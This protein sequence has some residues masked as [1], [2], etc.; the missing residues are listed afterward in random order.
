MPHPTR[1]N[2]LSSL[3]AFRETALCGLLRKEPLGF[4]DIGARGGAH[5]LVDPL[6][7]LIHVI[8]FEPDEDAFK[9]LE[10]ESRGSPFAKIEYSR[11]ALAERAGAHPLYL[12]E[13][14]TNHSLRQPNET[15]CRRYNMVKF[16]CRGE[17]TVD[18]ETLDHLLVPRLGAEPHLGELIK[19]DTQG[20][21]H[22]ILRGAEEILRRQTVALFVEVSFCPIY[23]G[24]SQFSELEIY[25]RG[26]GFVFHGFNEIHYRS[27]KALDKRHEAGRERLLFSDAIFFKDP[28]ETAGQKGAGERASGTLFLCA[29][30]FGH[31]DFALELLPRVTAREKERASLEAVVHHCAARNPSQ[32]VQAL[33]QLQERVIASPELANVLTGRFVDSRRSWPDYAE[34]VTRPPVPAVETGPLGF[35]SVNSVSGSPAFRQTQL[36]QEFLRQPLGFI[37]VGARGGIHTIVQPMAEVTAVLALEPDAP[38]AERLRE[39]SKAS[40]FQQVNI[41]ACGLAGR[42]GNYDLNLLA[43]SVNHSLL[44]PNQHLVDRYRIR[45]FEPAGT[46]NVPCRSLDSLLLGDLGGETFWGEF[47]KIDTQGAE[48]DILNGGLQVLRDRT[49]ALVVEACFFQLYENQRCFPDLEWWLRGQG[50]SLYGFDHLNYRSQKHLDKK[51]EA[52]RERL[53]F[54]DAIFFRDPFDEI[55]RGRSLTRRNIACLIAAAILLRYYDFALELLALWEAPEAERAGLRAA[56]HQAAFHSPAQSAA[57]VARLHQAVAGHPDW[58]HVLVGKFVDGRRSFPDYAEVV[59]T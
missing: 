48:Y 33:T 9:S 6:A 4:V 36:F 25:L 22:E 19:I 31:Y 42:D 53:F 17:T 14:D 59:L 27:R 49:V 16:A 34:I 39:E 58:A 15:F 7:E 44:S 23:A 45:G 32:T 37:D 57:E 11:F 13:A 29:L 8:G 52:G 18:C 41:Q 21:E 55:N 50:F 28:C 38:E 5:P 2:E 54:T 56:I 46:A 3:A 20:T 1:I 40:P 12:C 51:T 26:L 43:N 24:Q 30:I 35:T 10:R 47:I